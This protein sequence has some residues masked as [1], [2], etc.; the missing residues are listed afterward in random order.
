MLTKGEIWVGV[1]CIFLQSIV[2]ICEGDHIQSLELQLANPSL[3]HC[4][5]ALVQCN[6]VNETHPR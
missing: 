2:V 6:L 4:A 3:E 5:A 1:I